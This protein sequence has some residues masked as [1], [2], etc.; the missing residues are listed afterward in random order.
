[1]RAYLIATILAALSSLAC[2]RSG[3]TSLAPC[4]GV[5]QPCCGGTA[6]NADLVCRSGAC[7]EV[8]ASCG[9]LA[10][11][12]CDL[13]SCQ[14]GLTCAQTFCVPDVTSCGAEGA[15]CCSNSACS[16]DLICAAGMCVRFSDV[17]GSRDQSCC[18]GSLCAAG[19]ACVNSLCEASP[20][21]GA[22]QEAC[23]EG[24]ACNQGLS[25]IA[26]ICQNPCAQCDSRTCAG[27]SCVKLVFVSSQQYS[28]GSLGGLSGADAKCQALA[29][30]AGF[31]G[32]YL[33]WLSDDAGTSPATRFSRSN[34]YVQT[35]GAIVV[36]SW[37]QLVASGLS[38]GITL[39][40]HA[41]PVSSNVWTGTNGS[42]L[43]IVG[44]TCSGWTS[45]SGAGVV[46]DN[47]VPSYY[48]AN[49]WWWTDISGTGEVPSCS[50]PLPIDCF[51]Q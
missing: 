13:G 36:S 37:S 24:T 29:N 3:S 44:G 11:Q 51:E 32:T 8:V 27:T 25:C 46:G 34:S 33:A 4:G 50:T 10:E 31:H 1:M 26:S 35:N 6:C 41:S 18:F 42:A 22:S 14:Q 2:S 7:S 9:G 19:L 49:Y 20:P 47:N 17:C 16:P 28:G 23:C 5:S 15:S 38:H 45:M 43:A 39:D 21:C 40:E 30:A 12:C 48:A